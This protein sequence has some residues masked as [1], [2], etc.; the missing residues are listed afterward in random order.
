MVVFRGSDAA[1]HSG[2]TKMMIV[3]LTDFPGVESQ[4]QHQG[5]EDPDHVFAKTTDPDHVLAKEKLGWVQ[6]RRMR[7]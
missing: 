5:R 4:T 3:P 2:V 1:A 7:M 6:R